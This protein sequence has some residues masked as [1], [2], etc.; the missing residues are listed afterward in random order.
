VAAA[1][2]LVATPGNTQ[3]PGP[4]VID[5][6]YVYTSPQP[7]TG[8]FPMTLADQFLASDNEAIILDRFAVP[9]D[10]NGEGIQDPA[11]HYTWWQ[12]V[13]DQT[14]PVAAVAV[15]NQF[16]PQTLDVGLAAYLLNPALKNA[17]AGQEPPAN[18]DHYKCYDAV[19]S[20]IGINVN[21]SHQ[22]GTE[23][24]DVLDPRY[25]CNPVE[26]QLPS[27]VFP[28]VNPNEHL[29]CYQVSPGVPIPGITVGVLDQFV[30]LSMVLEFPELI[31]VPSTKEIPTQVS[32]GTWGEVKA[33]YR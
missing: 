6:Y 10:K 12:I 30:D 5:H 24:V 21:L 19:G 33:I 3:V 9:V 2:L 11:L 27:A 31:C 16:G 18:K 20:P 28:I 15:D 14:N 23:T 25:L 32:E 13:G 8:A 7:I 17:A 22:F 26:K 29:V 1:L 4:F